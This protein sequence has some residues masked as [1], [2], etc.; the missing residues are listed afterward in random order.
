M[1][2][3]AAA[4]PMR[5]AASPRIVEQIIEV[6]IGTLEIRTE[7]H[8][9]IELYL[10]EFLLQQLQS[11]STPARTSETCNVRVP[12]SSRAIGPLQLNNRLTKVETCGTPLT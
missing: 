1:V 10:L 3:D 11:N 8:M 4:G 6:K 9:K 12:S 7:V 5:V 2:A